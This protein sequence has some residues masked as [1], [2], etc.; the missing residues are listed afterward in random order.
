M[1]I[2]AS[3]IG[4]N[5]D[6]NG[7]ISS[8][9]KVES[10]PLL[11]LDK[12]EARVQ[13]ELS[14]YGEL[15][16]AVSTFQTAVKD[17]NNISKFQSFA[18]TSSDKTIFTATAA[19]TAIAGTYSVEV[20]QLAQAQK[21]AT[22]GQ[23][24]TTDAIGNG[25]M[26]FDFGT[27]S[28]T[29]VSGKYDPGATFTSNGSGTKTVTI[30][31]TNNSLTGIR[32]AINAAKVGVTATIVNDGGTSPYRL[33]L[34]SDNI[35]GKNSIKITVSGDA[36]L[37]TL[38]A[39]DPASVQNLTETV[40]AKD[41][42]LK[43]DGILITKTSNT[44]TDVIQGVTLNLLKENTGSPGTLTVTKDAA[45]LKS[46]VN[47]FVNAFNTVNTVIADLTAFDP[48]ARTSGLLQGDTSVLLIRR[49]IRRAMTSS[50]TAL[51]GSFKS[52]SDIG[53]SFQKDGSLA[54]DSSKLEAAINS[55][56]NDIASL[57]ASVGNT[58]DSLVKFSSATD[59]TQPGSYAVSVTT[60][61]TQGK[62]VGSAAGGLTITTGTN[63]TL[64]I[65][66]DG[67]NATVTL[68]AGTYT[69]DALATEVQSKINGASTFS[70]SGISVT[71]SQSAGIFAITSKGYGEVSKVNMTGGNG[72]TSLLG[73][74]PVETDGTDVVGTINGITAGGSGQFLTA[75][76]GNGAEGLKIQITGGTAPGS[77]GTV[78]YSQGYAFQLGMLT[79]AL[80]GTSGPVVSRTN[81]IDQ[82]IKE[83]GNQ[84]EV[85]KRHLIDVEDRFRKQFTSLD[86]LL[87][88]MQSTSSFLSQQLDMLGRLA[89][90]RL[91]K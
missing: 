10:R 29:L 27:I 32:D 60:L 89:S 63:D 55:N 86:I 83:I 75:G 88:K 15:K 65:T 44:V 52:L 33:S 28:G 74:S 12:K 76:G 87:S 70:T 17:L 84:R 2:S 34:S 26:T 80:L 49:Q 36:A 64:N 31:S 18:A 22:V 14:A 50:I 54:A 1:G 67:A 19:S 42:N 57:F 72:K 20:T 62:S 71:V 43:V 7:I 58:S 21:L 5:L 56:F 79:D 13:A 25:T 69:A 61:A 90:S 38:L 4:S 68:S 30:D 16:G 24:N 23:S 41:A 9:L 48:K 51:S 11:L 85:F 66:V 3:G 35:G 39:H 73:A 82:R 91:G 77:R 40:S 46:S 45:A 78:N 6:I 81:R 47:T 37:S 59:K 8:L 53:V